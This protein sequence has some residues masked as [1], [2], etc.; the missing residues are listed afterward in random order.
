MGIV[1]HELVLARQAAFPTL[2]YIKIIIYHSAIYKIIF[3]HSKHQGAFR[4]LYTRHIRHGI[5][6]VRRVFGEQ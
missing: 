4:A 2:H 3:K 6:L 5:A 1:Y